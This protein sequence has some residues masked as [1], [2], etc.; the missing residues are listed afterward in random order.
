MI[1]IHAIG[2]ALAAVLL[3]SAPAPAAGCYRQVVVEFERDAAKI[4]NPS[5]VAEFAQVSTYGSRQ[6]LD[7]RIDAPEHSLAVR[8]VDAL[9]DLLQSFGLDRDWI[10]TR[11]SRGA[12]ER[13]VILFWPGGPGPEARGAGAQAAQPRSSCGG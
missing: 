9:L 1:R 12:G 13:A 3:S 2:F 5:A 10:R 11:A 7:V 8:R 4:A 6:K